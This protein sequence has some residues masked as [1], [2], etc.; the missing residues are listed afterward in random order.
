M[1][2]EREVVIAIV[3]QGSTGRKLSLIRP[4][5]SCQC[6]I[7]YRPSV[8]NLHLLNSVAGI[9]DWYIDHTNINGNIYDVI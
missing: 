7:Q 1:A 4:H 5:I 6:Y 2:R 3:V 8:F 9:G